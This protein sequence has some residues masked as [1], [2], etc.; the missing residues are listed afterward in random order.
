MP[1]VIALKKHVVKLGREKANNSIDH[2]DQPRMVSRLHATINFLRDACEWRVYDNGSVNGTLLQRKDSDTA[3]RV[4]EASLKHGDVIT[5][6][7]AVA[8]EVGK[9]PAAN[10]VKS[11][12]SYKF[13][14]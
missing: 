5:F 4:S 6:G 3:I 8:T 12:Y 13:I 10:A 7:G 14:T 9:S 1:S 11:I 2:K